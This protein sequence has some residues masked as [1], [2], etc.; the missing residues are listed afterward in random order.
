MRKEWTQREVIEI[1][2]LLK[3]R[4]FDRKAIAYYESQGV[5]PKPVAQL[6]NV[7]TL[8]DDE[9]IEVGLVDV[10]RRMR[11]PVHITY[12]DIAIAKEKVLISNKAKNMSML[13]RRIKTRP[14]KVI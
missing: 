3:L 6:K 14:V 8:Y 12:E 9:E 7:M 10:G 1:A 4:N 5:F 11:N 13:L 2:K